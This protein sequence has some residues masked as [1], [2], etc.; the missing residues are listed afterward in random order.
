MPVEIYR[1][2]IVDNKKPHIQDELYVTIS[3]SGN[4]YL[5]GERFAFKPGDVIFVPAE[6]ERR[7]EDFKPDFATWV[8]FYGPLGGEGKR[9]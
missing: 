7:F 1:P 8:I 5:A 9:P 4:F 3:G 2:A 6:A